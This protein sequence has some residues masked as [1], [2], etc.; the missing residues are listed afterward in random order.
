MAWWCRQ[1]RGSGST[2]PRARRGRPGVR[3][4]GGGRRG[5]EGEEGVR[6]M[7]RGGGLGCEAVTTAS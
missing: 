7:G 1:L 5:G 4:I 3:L 2:C 6:V